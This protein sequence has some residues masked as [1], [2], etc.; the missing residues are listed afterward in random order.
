MFPST[1]TYIC[2]QLIYAIDDGKTITLKE[3][4]HELDYK[5]NIFEFLNNKFS[6]TFDFSLL[7]QID[8]EFLVDHYQDIWLAHGPK[9]FGG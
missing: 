8:T 2:F 1:L 5:N 6:D 3:L 4:E 9:K 7:K